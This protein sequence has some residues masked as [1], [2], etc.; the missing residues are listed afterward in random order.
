MGRNV[1][2]QM[3]LGT[4]VQYMSLVTSLLQRDKRMVWTKHEENGSFVTCISVITEGLL[5]AAVVRLN[6]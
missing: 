5:K 1:Q 6:F 4:S 2:T 3:F